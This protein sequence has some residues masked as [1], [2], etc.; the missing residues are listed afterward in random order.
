MFRERNLGGSIQQKTGTQTFWT[1][2]LRTIMFIL[3][4][5]MPNFAKLAEMY[6]STILRK[7]SI[8]E[9]R[10]K[11]GRFLTKQKVTYKGGNFCLTKKNFFPN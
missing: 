6:I 7:K 2:K 1:I 3:P 5:F 9:N 11:T 8:A 10:K 4:C